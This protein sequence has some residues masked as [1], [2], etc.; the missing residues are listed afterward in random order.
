[1]RPRFRR[2]SSLILWVSGVL[3]VITLGCGEGPFATSSP[4]SAGRGA[5]LVGTLETGTAASEVRALS[6]PGRSGIRV[7]VMGMSISAT[8]DESGRFVL[9]GL[10][11]GRVELRIEGQGL[12]ARVEIRGLVDGQT[13]TLTIQLSGGQQPVIVGPG[14]QV[15][16][17]IRGAVESVT[18]PSLRV[19]T[20]TIVTN[21]S[22][23]IRG[24]REETIPLGAIQVGDFVKVEGV[25]L[26]D[27]TIQ[28][29]RVDVEEE[30]EDNDNDEEDEVEFTGTITAKGASSLVVAGRTVI[31]DTNTRILGRHN[32]PI[33]FSS[34]AVGQRVEVEGRPLAGG[35]V[36]AE[37]IKLED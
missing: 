23:R 28:A 16:V 6:G 30:D 37:K 17:K 26:S 2:S 34:L 1:M 8:T 20:R 10:P 33:P 12:D 21:A 24:P 18:P 29:S 13:L 4:T 11:S 7:S 22:T 14:E 35:A 32:D 3:A 31:V 27:G 25:L 15:E 5:T 9:T 36:L 19:L